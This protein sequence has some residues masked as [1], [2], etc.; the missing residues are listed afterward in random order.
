MKRSRK[1]SAG[2]IIA[3]GFFTLILTGTVLL[4]LPVTHNAGKSVPVADALF[5]ATSATCVT[6]LSTI[7]VAD[8]FNTFG[9]T[10]I[11]LLIQC[12][13]LGVAC[14]GATFALLLGRRMGMKNQ[15]LVREGWNMSSADGV[16]KL[17]K[18]AL[19]I[20]LVTEFIGALISF[21]VF[22]QDMPI[23]RAAGTAVFHSVSAFN[24]AGFDILGADS[25]IPYQGNVL[26]ILTTAVLILLGGL[27][28]FVFWD[29]REKKSFHKL[30]LH[31]KIV[32]FTTGILLLLGTVA[33][34]A[35]SRLSWLDSF[36]LSVSSRTAG[37]MTSPIAKLP[38]AALFV[39]IL[40]MFIGA[41]P[42]STGGG[43]KT[44]TFFAVC[45]IIR[46]QI[47]GKKHQA[48]HRKL[49]KDITTKALLLLL[50]AL[51]VVLFATFLL[52]I[53]E[54]EMNFL[55]LLVEVVSSAATVGLS[56]GIT[57]SLSVP[58]KI[59]LTLVMYVGRLG[60][61][62]A[63]TIWSIREESALSYSEESITIG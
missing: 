41:S 52:C 49:P 33:F 16:V 31:S 26:L 51:M 14:M 59:V 20:T 30:T 36:F 34:F 24:N 40:L 61:L 25:L 37:F 35:L 48:F 5:I 10:V 47:S 46:G 45:L 56:T 27:G 8:T 9:K 21:S 38:T 28:F 39:L 57:Q 3:L 2:R 29:L 54:P 1:L 23:A 15:S 53:F 22:V 63:A 17:L 13:G 32:L 12:G 18:M 42:G 7:V 55:D 43:L 44:T 11:A 50:F 19:L 4:S 58:S 60:P 62:S 6:G